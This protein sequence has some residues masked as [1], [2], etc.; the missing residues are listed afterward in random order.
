M[1]L[2]QHVPKQL[3]WRDELP[4]AATATA[5]TELV[6]RHLGVDET[7]GSCLEGV[8]GERQVQLGAEDHDRGRVRAQL[9]VE[10]DTL[11]ETF[12]A[13]GAEYDAGGNFTGGLGP[14]WTL[15]FSSRARTRPVLTNE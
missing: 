5:R 3:P 4:L 9:P 12:V 14:W 8:A 2:G 15:A 13:V 11:G 6:G 7:G 10:L 1:V